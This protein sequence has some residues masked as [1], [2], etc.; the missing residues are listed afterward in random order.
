MMRREGIHWLSTTTKS[1]EETT[2]LR[3]IRPGDLNTDPAGGHVDI[4][5]FLRQVPSRVPG[6]SGQAETTSSTA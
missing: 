3:E 2:I 6:G 4:N 1:I 5:P